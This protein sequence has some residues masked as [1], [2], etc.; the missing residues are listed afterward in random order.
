MKYNPDIHKRRYIRLK[1]YDYSQSGF[2]FITIC[3]Y[4]RQCLF[5]EIID[6]KMQLNKIGQ[7][8]KEEWLKSEKIR[9]EIELDDWVIMP[10]HFHGIVIIDQKINNNTNHDY[11]PVGANGRS[12]LQ[13]NLMKPKSLS[14]LIAGFKA[15]TTKQINLI[16]NSP[17][18]PVWQRN[19]YDHVIRNNQSLEKIKEYI[20]N[21]PL[22][23]ELDQ[24]NPN[25][26]SKW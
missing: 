25:N 4:Q 5:G 22:S 1:G 20:Y 14:S 15:A 21:N 8:V 26:P 11:N 6:E 24:L 17:K 7:L 2:Y 3:C 12:P 16:R 18:Y 13:T 10:N 23:W 9:Q 19:Y